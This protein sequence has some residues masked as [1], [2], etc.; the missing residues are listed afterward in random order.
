MLRHYNI[1]IFIPELAC[2]H[3][4]V[5]CDQQKISGKKQQPSIEDVDHIVKAYLATIPVAT[6]HVEIAFF[7]GNFTGL[8]ADTQEAY[9]EK[10]A[11]W[12]K[13]E[14][15]NGIRLST[16]PDYINE[17]N[18]Q[19]LKHHGVTCI[20]IGAQSFDDQVLQLSGRGHT[21]SDIENA[22]AL[23]K[24][25]GIS[26]VIQMMTGLPGDTMNKTRHTARRIVECGAV[27]T[28]IYPAVVI[29]STQLEQLLDSGQ[30]KPLSMEETI[31]RCKWLI[32][33]F[34]KH[35][36]QILRLGLH[37]SEGLI[38]G[39]ELVEGP[40]HPAMKE[41]VLSSMWADLFSRLLNEQDHELKQKDLIICVAPRQLSVAVGHHGSN[42]EALEKIYRKVVFKTDP[43]LKGRAFHVHYC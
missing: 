1:P 7:G 6:K 38:S 18:L 4:C 3:Q 15:V 12:I 29:R 17:Q 2:P 36:I 30:Y 40:F 32:H 35:Q 42:K 10:A 28:R 14:Q 34:E 9:L 22:A 21:V 8:P 20:E 41:L 23:I 5:F 24:R 27:A 13:Q 33:Y 19:M 39:C 26:L 11:Y 43:Q 16:R 25:A 31:D 37:P